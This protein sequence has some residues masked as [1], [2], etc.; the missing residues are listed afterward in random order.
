MG[1]ECLPKE[2]LADRPAGWALEA[3]IRFVLLSRPTMINYIEDMM[4]AGVSSIKFAALVNAE[5]ENDHVALFGLLCSFA[6]YRSV[7]TRVKKQCISMNAFMI[8]LSARFSLDNELA[9]CTGVDDDLD[10]PE[11]NFV[12]PRTCA[13][14][15]L[16]AFPAF[17]ANSAHLCAT[18]SSYRY[19]PVRNFFLCNASPT[20]FI[21]TYPAVISAEMSA[22]N[23]FNGFAERFIQLCATLGAGAFSA[24]EMKAVYLCMDPRATMVT[25]FLKL[26]IA[27][28]LADD[29]EVIQTAAY[30][31]RSMSA[32]AHRAW[33]ERGS[34]ALEEDGIDVDRFAIEFK[35]AKD[36]LMTTAHVERTR[37]AFAS[38][39]VWA[40]P[41]Q[42]ASIAPL[43][44]TMMEQ[45]YHP[46]NQSIGDACIAICNPPAKG[47]HE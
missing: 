6:V 45:H 24:E 36:L 29:G 3:A 20:V 40:T 22:R 31:C 14:F 11:Q 19:N 30:A 7:R 46:A 41:S 43:V 35:E 38:L 1:L 42:R 16:G 44:T 25:A 12:A 9:W 15:L 21:R 8:A 28:V 2:D 23:P 39:C 37:Q 5:D 47:A 13:T 26:P 10:A 27:Q 18:Y 32:D 33:M 34:D 17:I 4:K